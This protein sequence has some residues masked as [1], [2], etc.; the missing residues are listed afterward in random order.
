MCEAMRG[1]GGITQILLH[2]H[3]TSTILHKVIVVLCVRKYEPKPISTLTNT[4]WSLQAG[5]RHRRP[6]AAPQTWRALRRAPGCCIGRA[7]VSCHP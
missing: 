3:K 4:F 6:L 1:T 2:F 7:T 5:P